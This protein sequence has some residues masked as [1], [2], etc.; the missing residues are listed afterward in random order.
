MKSPAVSWSFPRRAEPYRLRGQTGTAVTGGR[1]RPPTAGDRWLT[2]CDLLAGARELGFLGAGPVSGHIA[3]SR[4]FAE[5]VEARWAAEV[6]RGEPTA[7]PPRSV[8]DLG[9]GAGVPGL[10]LALRWEGTSFVL[11]ESHA[12]RAAFLLRSVLAL[13]LTARVTVIAERAE[14]VGRTPTK[15]GTAD[16]VTA[17]GFA[18]PAVVA[19]CASPLLG[20]GG[21]LVV[22]EPPP[23][24]S[25]RGERWPAQG[26]EK[27]GMGPA[28]SAESGYRFVV[29]TQE[30]ACPPRF[31]RR[32]GVPRKRPLF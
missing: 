24:A 26:L 12:R 28:E 31:P 18:R 21:L 6:A 32:T 14:V 1:A 3:Q 7:G 10:I 2:L 19:E 20:V 9:S 22:S 17:R 29:V 5:V 23:D 11:V 8:V 13:D 30:Q 15:R 16:V 27:L 25:P 4:A